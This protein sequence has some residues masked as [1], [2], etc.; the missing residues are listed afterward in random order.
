MGREVS[1]CYEENNGEYSSTISNAIAKFKL[2]AIK[3]K[4]LALADIAFDLD[5]YKGSNDILTYKCVNEVKGVIDAMI[6]LGYGIDTVREYFNNAVEDFIAMLKHAI[7]KIKE[8]DDEFGYSINNF[9][10]D[11]DD[12]NFILINY[13]NCYNNAELIDFME[14]M[15][16]DFHIFINRVNEYIDE[17]CRNNERYI[18]V[19]KVKNRIKFAFISL[20]FILLVASVFYTIIK[21]L[22]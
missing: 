22:F 4:I 7:C 19:I 14:S 10:F 2:Y 20:M 12:R 3:D 16:S 8:K 15:I 18:K 5:Y 1:F 11:N 17:I 13:N 9:E 21:D 6:R